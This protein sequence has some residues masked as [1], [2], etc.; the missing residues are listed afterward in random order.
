MV[1]GPTGA[2]LDTVADILRHDRDQ[3]LAVAAAAC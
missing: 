1:A 3:A 2:G